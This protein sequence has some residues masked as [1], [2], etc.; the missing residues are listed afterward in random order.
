MPPPLLGHFRFFSERTRRR[1]ALLDRF[2][3]QTLLLIF[4][5]E[6]VLLL[7]GVA[8]VALSTFF[9]HAPDF[10]ANGQGE[11]LSAPVVHLVLLTL[12]ADVAT[13][14]AVLQHC[15]KQALLFYKVLL[16]VSAA[17]VLHCREVLQAAERRTQNSAFLLFQLQQQQQKQQQ[18]QQ[19]Q[20][21]LNHQLLVAPTTSIWVDGFC[22]RHAPLLVNLVHLNRH[23]V[24]PLLYAFYQPVLI[25]SVYT[26]CLL[27]FQR[28]DLLETFFLL[29]SF[30]SMAGTF[31][32]L[33]FFAQVQWAL[34]EGADRRL[35]VAQLGC[36]AGK[37]DQNTSFLLRTK[38]KLMAYY[39]VLCTRQKIAFTFGS[40]AKVEYRWLGEVSGSALRR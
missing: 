21:Q 27:T 10:L 26:L 38:L 40:L 2:L 25:F 12:A 20:P 22:G 24:S 5:G 7:P 29:G 8:I 19:Q 16:L 34:Y 3:E 6:S 18:Q 32:F 28:R 14:F 15:F 11:Q 23:L 36:T 9:K 31:T 39:E 35:Y 4:L 1:L 37:R 17:W 33:L 30:L 13:I